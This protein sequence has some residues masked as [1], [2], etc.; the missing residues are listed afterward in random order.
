MNKKTYTRQDAELLTLLDLNGIIYPLES[1]YWV[2]FSAR[3]VKPTPQIP[4]GI[5]YSLTL[6]DRNNTRVL[7]YDNAHSA[8]RKLKG[9]KKYRARKLSWDHQHHQDTVTGYNFES[10]SQLLD[11]FWKNVERVVKG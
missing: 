9:H 8:K 6:H 2:K 7:G 3:K 5:S 1:G 4:H 10:A 11:D